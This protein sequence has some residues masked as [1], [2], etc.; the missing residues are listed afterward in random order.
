MAFK[1]RRSA[2]EP[3]SEI[4]VTPFVDVMLVLLIIFMVTAP[5]LTVGVQVDLPETSAD[6]LPEETEPLT[7]TINAKGEIFIQ[8]TKVEYEKIIAKIMAVSNNRTDTRIFVRGDKTINYGR[9]LEVMGMLSGSG[10]TKVALIS[11]P[12]KER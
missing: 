6:T 3:I 7:L 1:L 4:N 10:F 5:L 9:V 2:K 11:E 12:Y 8:E